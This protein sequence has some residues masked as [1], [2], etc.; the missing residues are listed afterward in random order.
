M[1]N[2]AFALL[3]ARLLKSMM[4]DQGGGF[5]VEVQEDTDRAEATIKK[6]LY[7][8]IFEQEQKSQLLQVCCCSQDA[9]WCEP[10]PEILLV[11]DKM[12]AAVVIHG[13]QACAVQLIM[14]E[15]LQ[16]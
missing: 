3:Q 2:F 11:A 10:Q 4:H 16:V 8:T 14:P 7:H 6:C 9:P 1:R 12:H 15:C 13:S 5:E